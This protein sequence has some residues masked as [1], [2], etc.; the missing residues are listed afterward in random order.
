MAVDDILKWLGA[1]SPFLL[2]AGGWAINRRLQ[3][4]N[5]E[6][7]AAEARLADANVDR[8]NVDVQNLI[9]ANTKELLAEARAVQNEKDA[10]KDERIGQLTGRVNRMESRFEALRTALATHG[11][12]D[13]AALIDLRTAKPDY[14]PPPPFPRGSHPDDDED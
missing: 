14:P 7:V 6:K 3:R 1:L 12:W 8:A 13:A 2:L 4:A 5:A 10:I 9:I 11:V